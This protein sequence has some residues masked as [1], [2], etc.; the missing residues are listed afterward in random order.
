V[1][2]QHLNP[3]GVLH[4]AGFATFY[5]GSLG[6]DPHVSL[7]QIFFHGRGL[8]VKGDPLP[9]PVGAFGLQ[10][11]SRSSGD[12]PMYTPADSNW[13]WHEEWF[14][15]RNPM[16]VTFPVFTGMRPV[17]QNSW[18]RGP[19]PRRRGVWHFSRGRCGSVS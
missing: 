18:H 8:T 14:Y 17:K 4:I 5:E 13:G 19:Q 10:K 11:R 9:T 16:E 6:I 7:F 15:V 12:Y 2:L 1:E 3:N